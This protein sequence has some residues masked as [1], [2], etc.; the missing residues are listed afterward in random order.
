LSHIFQNGDAIFSFL[1]FS[2]WINIGKVKT[3]EIQVIN[4]I[5]HS[6]K[7]AWLGQEKFGMKFDTV[8]FREERAEMRLYS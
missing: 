1:F 6:K 3:A 8:L 7:H 5:S 4:F 2:F